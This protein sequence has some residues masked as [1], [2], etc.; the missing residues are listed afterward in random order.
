MIYKI[1]FLYPELILYLGEI[2]SRRLFCLNKYYYRI[3]TP[4]I[5]V[6]MVS[7]EKF[8][9]RFNRK[10]IELFGGFNTFIEFPIFDWKESFLGETNYIDNILPSD[11]TSPV[12]IG[13]DS[14]SRPFIALRINNK[15]RNENSISVTILFQR[16][17][18]LSYSWTSG[19]VGRSSIINEGGLFLMNNKI[20]HY[21]LPFNICNLLEKKGY[22]FNYVD[23]I[24]NEIKYKNNVYLE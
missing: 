3:M 1:D 5:N 12:M 20:T 19:I 24:N 21:L 15:K 11:M 2:H 23:M 14:W 7:L 22:V 18:N 13:L 10:I 8:V 16:Y 6:D 17:T 4:F 9:K